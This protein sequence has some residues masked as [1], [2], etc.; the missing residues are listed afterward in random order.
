MKSGL[1]SAA[2]GGW[3]LCLVT[4]SA[5][6][7]ALTI[8]KVLAF[9]TDRQGHPR[10]GGLQPRVRPRV[11]QVPPRPAREPDPP[12]VRLQGRATAAGLVRRVRRAGDDGRSG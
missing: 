9:A 12:D 5:A 1:L 8:E 4:S 10:R 7:A 3:V 11:R 2:L 6:Q